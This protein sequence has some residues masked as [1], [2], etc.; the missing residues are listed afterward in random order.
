[1][2]CVMVI[3]SK[4][5]SVILIQKLLHVCG[6]LINAVSSV[7]RMLLVYRICSQISLIYSLNSKGPRIETLGSPYVNMQ[8]QNAFVKHGR[9]SYCPRRKSS[10]L[11]II[12]QVL[13][14]KWK[15]YCYLRIR[16]IRFL[17]Q[18]TWK[19]FFDFQN[20]LYKKKNP[21]FPCSYFTHLH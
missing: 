7:K 19:H 11:L 9:N 8:K 18:S 13:R 16:W 21:N 10:Y 15:K 17:M 14:S 2:R 4:F 12:L 20:T 1:M 5:L 3:C 6:I